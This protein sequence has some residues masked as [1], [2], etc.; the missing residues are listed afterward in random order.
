MRRQLREQSGCILLPAPAVQETSSSVQIQ[1]Q[2]DD[3]VRALTSAFKETDI[4]IGPQTKPFMIATGCS[5]IGAAT[6]ALEVSKLMQ[7][8]WKE[9]YL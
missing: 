7:H 6:L 5:G 8:R 2:P 4:R 1:V 3:W 9:V